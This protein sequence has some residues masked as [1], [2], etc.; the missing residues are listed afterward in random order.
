MKAR[1]VVL[2]VIVAALASQNALAQTVK[3]SVVGTGS[4]ALCFNAEFTEQVNCTST[5]AVAAP[6]TDLE[7]GNGERNAQGGCESRVVTYAALPPITVPPIVEN[8]TV[9]YQITDYDPSTGAGDA[10]FTNYMG[11]SC[12]SP[13]GQNFAPRPVRWF[14][15]P[16][17]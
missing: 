17:V 13:A 3:Y 10:N 4:F 9:V 2:L 11:G 1:F 7:V 5:S 6:L 15:F 14:S 16:A 8:V 12:N